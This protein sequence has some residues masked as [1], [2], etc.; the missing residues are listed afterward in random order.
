[1]IVLFQFKIRP[2]PYAPYFDQIEMFTQVHSRI[3]KLP[4]FRIGETG[5]LLELVDVGSFKD[6]VS[7]C[8]RSNV[9][10]FVVELLDQIRSMFECHRGTVEWLREKGV[11]VQQIEA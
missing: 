4:N 8:R 10:F 3:Q 2:V 11:G 6:L 7:F 5:F 9:E 1:M